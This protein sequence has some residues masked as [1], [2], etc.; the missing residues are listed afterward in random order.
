MIQKMCRGYIVRKSLRTEVGLIK[1]QN[2]FKHFDEM[3]LSLETNAQ[4]VIA[5]H[6][7]KTLKKL[8]LVKEEEEAK[9]KKKADGKK[10]ATAGTQRL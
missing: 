10:K 1:M 2:V 3:K 9:K 4:I 6:M 5:Y 7:R 8:R